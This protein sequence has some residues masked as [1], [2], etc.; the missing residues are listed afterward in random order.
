MYSHLLF[1]QRPDRQYQNGRYAY[2]IGEPYDSQES[3]EWKRGWLDKAEESDYK[4]TTPP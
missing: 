1:E 3:S 4:Q 2:Q